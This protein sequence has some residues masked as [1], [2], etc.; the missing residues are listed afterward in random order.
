[1]EGPDPAAPVLRRLLEAAGYRLEDRRSGLLAV[2]AADRRVVFLVQ[3]RR[4]PTE[5]EEELPSDM[6]HRSLVYDEDPGSIAREIASNRG[7]EI[8]D[9]CSLGP[10]LGE[11]LLPGPGPAVDDPRLSADRPLEAPAQILPEGELSLRPRLGRPD[12]EAMSGVDGLRYTLRF[13]PFFVAPYRVRVA[14][15]QGNPGLPSDHLVAV[16]ALSGRVEV[17]EAADRELS[18]DA[19]GPIEKLVPVITESMAA[20][21]AQEALRKR[22]T[23]SVD[24]TEQ[25][26][27]AIIIERR[28]VAP[29][30]SDLRIGTPVLVYVPYWY[31]EGS[32]GRIVLDAVTGARRLPGESELIDV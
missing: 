22:H 23:V 10:A 14:T 9:A 21:S 25:H 4:S 2:R 17:W 16:N 24:H 30:G 12:A 28:R 3:G 32:E 18:T 13:V 26:G 27:G 7:I 29:G 5:V 15:P 1:M 8:L 11:L 19:L 31:G 6:V 20:T